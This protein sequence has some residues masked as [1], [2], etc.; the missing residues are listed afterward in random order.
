M[1]AFYRNSIWLIA[2]ICLTITGCASADKVTLERVVDGDTIEVNY[3]GRSEPLRLI[4]IDT[5][6]SH[7]NDKAI[8]ISKEYHESLKSILA[9]GK[10]ATEFLR[11]FVTPGDS[12]KLEFDVEKRD[13]YNRL[14]GYVFLSDGRMLNEIII[15]SGYAYPLTIA[16]NVKHAKLFKSEFQL[17][18][19]AQLGLWKK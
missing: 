19:K 9:Q 7:P 3:R 5:P 12:L 17:A 14:L 2:L 13:K 15:Q 11:T 10:K 8:R 6:E 16:P 1:N 4:G 18:R